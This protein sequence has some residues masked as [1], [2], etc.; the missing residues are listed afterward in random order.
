MKACMLVV[1]FAIHTAMAGAL[2]LNGNREFHDNVAGHSTKTYTDDF[3]SSFP[4]H[5]VFDD[6]CDRYT[7]VNLNL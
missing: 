1:V 2:P 3:I 4:V 5:I 7:D 6:D